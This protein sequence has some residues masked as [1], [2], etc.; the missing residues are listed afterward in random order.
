MPRVDKIADF[1]RILKEFYIGNKREMPWREADADGT[2]DPYKIL[3]SEVM[4]QQ[5]QVSRVENY[6][7]VFLAQFPDFG[8]LANASLETVL[9]TWKGLGYNRRARY[10]RECAVTVVNE[11][12]SVLPADVEK[13]V[14]LPGIGKNTAGAIMVYAYN[15]PAIFIE[16][17]I[18]TVYLYHF[19]QKK[20]GKVSDQEITKFLEATIDTRNPREFYWALMDYGTFLKK[21]NKH[22][23]HQ[24]AHHI[25]QTKFEGSMRQL[26]ARILYELAEGPVSES[27]VKRKFN[28]S[29]IPRVLT[30][31]QK[32]RMIVTRAGRLFIAD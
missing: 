28:D 20:T 13:L 8:A 7:A 4:L 18:R 29:R 12:H 3:V 22:I 1:Q 25:K 17:N 16:T 14:K 30:A 15:Q 32:D 24:S 9:K 6:Y 23:N 11:C 26:R 10:L 2:F 31:L 27:S 5:T 21:S 19:F